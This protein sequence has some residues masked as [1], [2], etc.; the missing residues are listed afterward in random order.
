LPHRV[1]RLTAVRSD[2]AERGAVEIS[3]PLG[4]KIRR[5]RRAIE[6]PSFLHLWKAAAT[7]SLLPST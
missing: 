6:S 4:T 5:P 2:V 3:L 7:R 1:V